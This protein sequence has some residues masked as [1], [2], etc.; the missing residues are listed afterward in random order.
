MANKITRHIPNIITCCNLIS[1]CVATVMAI[2]GDLWLA[3][4]FIVVG[5][6]FDF[7]DGMTARLLHISSPIGKELD[8]LADVITFGLAPSAMLFHQ[9]AVLEYPFGSVCRCQIAVFLPFAAFL[10]TAFSA[11]RLAKFNL[12]ERQ[13]TSFIGLPTPANALLWGSLLLGLDRQ[14]E[15][16]NWAPLVLIA[17]MLLSCW[18]LVAELPMFALKFKNWGW[19]GNEVRYVFVLSCIPLLI[20]FKGLAFAIIIAWYVLLSVYVNATKKQ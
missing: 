13:T 8:S 5:A 10:M 1:G 16:V 20:I 12:D 19:K 3:L 15:T 2:Y 6:V 14:I 4:L 7:F 18:L 11:L 9:L 17:L